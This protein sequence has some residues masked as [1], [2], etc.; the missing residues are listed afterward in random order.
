M[1][2]L[3][4]GWVNQMEASMSK[5]ALRVLGTLVVVLLCSSQVQA[6]A[7]RGSS[8]T[9]SP[10]DR[11]FVDVTYDYGA[12]LDVIVEDLMIQH[13]AQG[14]SLVPD[15]STINLFGTQRNLREYAA[16]LQQFA[17]AHLGD[18]LENT[19]PTLGAGLKGYALSFFTADGTGHSRSGLVHLQVAFD[20]AGDAPAVNF[21]V[22]FVNSLL[23]NVAGDEYD[24]AADLRGLSVTVQSRGSV[25]EPASA[26]LV[27]TGIVMIGLRQRRRMLHLA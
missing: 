3:V 13:P 1:F 8:A 21:G 19:D 10:G 2:D 16:L 20:I 4:Q 6:L 26:W 14:L 5:A 25:P 9:G 22:S 27:L 18:A 24:Y 17:H 11:V 23:V 7:V 12:G 15:A